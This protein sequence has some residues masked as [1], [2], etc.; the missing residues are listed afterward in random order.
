MPDGSK[1]AGAG[2]AYNHAVYK[3]KGISLAI[4]SIIAIVVK[5]QHQYHDAA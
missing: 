5:V 3:R 4:Q 2:D 1:Q